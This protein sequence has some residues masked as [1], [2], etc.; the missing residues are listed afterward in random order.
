MGV[1]Y[2][3]GY[4]LLPVPLMIVTL[5]F[6]AVLV[7]YIH[8][9][10]SAFVAGSRMGMA[11]GMWEYSWVT[12]TLASFFVSWLVLRKLA[13][14]VRGL[15]VAPTP[16]PANFVHEQR[17]LV[18]RFR[19][20]L[21]VGDR[22]SRSYREVWENDPLLWKELLTHASGRWSREKVLGYGISAALF[23]LLLWSFTQGES[24]ETFIFLGCFYALLT[25]ANGA[26]LFAP[27]KEGRRMDMLLS[28]PVS[29]GALVRSK[30]LSGLLAPVSVRVTLLGL[31][32]VLAFSWWSGVL[33]VVIHLVVF[34]GFLLAVFLMASTASL[35]AATTQGAALAALGVICLI[36][37]V[38]PIVVSI[39][40]PAGFGEVTGP[41]ALLSA[42]NPVWVLAPLRHSSDLNPG[43]ALGR[44]SLFVL[45]YGGAAFGL[46]G[47]I[48]W[49]FDRVMGRA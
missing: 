41:L 46:I 39:A 15:V 38:L 29:T 44:C 35:H 3:I 37:L 20:A 34:F 42:L 49:R 14:R 26:S 1:L 43:A 5:G 7:P 47:W 11:G 22:P 31:A 12:A 10:Y 13:G 40:V 36:L 19:V 30:L 16:T 25:I 21:N 18:G 2:S 23:M 4:L 45:A 32:T 24:R 9:V 48:R 8:P 6:G 17:N 33:G 28:C 27:E